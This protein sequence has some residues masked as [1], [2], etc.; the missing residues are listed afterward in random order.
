V[1]S[2]LRS[3]FM[4][5]LTKPSS[6]RRPPI[7]WLI[8]WTLFLPPGLPEILSSSHAA[9]PHQA[10]AQSSKA[11][12]DG[13][14][15]R[16]YKLASG[17]SVMV[18]QPQ[19]ASWDGQKHMVAWSAISYEAQGAQEP[20]LGT[21]KI[22]A[23]TNVSVS[24][25]L[26]NFGAFR[27]TEF[28]FPTL[29]RDHAQ[30]AVSEFEK[31]MPAG[32][33][34]IALDR[35]LAGLDKSQISSTAGDAAGIKADP[36]K[37]YHSTK[38]AVLMI[39]DGQPV[40]SP[41]KD[42]DLKYAVNTNWDVFEEPSSKTFYLRDDKSWLKANDIN[43]PW[44]P[45]GKLP[46]SF[47]KLPA[48]D[49]WIDV[50]ANLP[51]QQI[52]SGAVPMVFESFEPAELI[53]IKGDPKFVPVKGT[54]L[55]WVSNTESDLFRLGNTGPY[56][57]LVAGRWFSAPN[58]SGPWTFATTSLPDDFK[59]IPVD[60]PRSR[61]LASVPGTDQAVEAV[62]LASVPQTARV[63]KTELK[64]PE[65][66]YQGGNP[67][68]KPIETTTLERAVNT[69]KQ[70]IKAGDLYYMC[71]QGV[72]FMA[73]S[74][75]GPWE[76]A[77]SV[78]KEIYTIPASSPAYNVTYVTV[79]K[80]DSGS[81]DWVKFVALAGY[82]GMMIAWGC[83]VW[84]SGWYYPPYVWYG[85]AYP[86]YFWH[87]ATYG[88][89]AW[90]NPY[91]GVYGRGVAAYGPYGGAGA[92][93]AYNPRTGTY[94]RGGS[95][96]GPYGSRSYAQGYNPWTGAHGATRQG[97]NIY[98]NWGSSY[99]Q[100]GDDWA[101]T[102]HVT[103]YATGRTTAGA[104][105]SEGGAGI[106]TSGPGGSGSVARS[107]S[108]DVY[109]GHDGNVYRKQDDSWQKY[110][111]GGWSNVDKPQANTDK[112]LSGQTRQGVAQTGQTGQTGQAGNR[113]GLSSSDQLNRDWGA[114]N[115]GAQRVRDNQTYRAGGGG[116]Q[117][118]GSYRGGGGFRGGGFGR[119]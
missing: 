64:A 6:F 83:T 96:Y 51:G 115:D 79:E 113:A 44:A 114:R 91:T 48:N 102:G 29:S 10:A 109:A 69:D 60:H 15:P 86:A 87:P 13:G 105:G 32:D 111:D 55:L 68:F 100:R 92:W 16:S 117:M 12:T 42:V 49:N 45:A 85:G 14:W 110:G 40:W 94:A 17:D 107:G 63:N 35:V 43:G 118:G 5:N 27:I 36:P 73:R 61:V 46:D 71:F 33:R 99:V 65:V 25:R 75:D 93:G 53:L 23:D 98:G 54:S 80:D 66:A 103:N 88:T 106:R 59:R 50:R 76:V 30:K 19:I 21:V 112:N 4:S 119:R 22:E 89:A 47:G 52:A 72:W 74:A 34:V 37:I 1:I 2:R 104:R 62:L 90:Y 41:I 58:L 108:G 82:T 28:N 7:A 56:Y 18:Y 67:E 101:Q 11:P 57:Y 81:D 9:S 116:R 20:A 95:V 97:S 38:P 84:G 8:A 77:S 24:E 39:F 31:A 26:V 70:I 3:I 78:P